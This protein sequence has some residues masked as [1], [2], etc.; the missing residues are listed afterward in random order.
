M[1]TAEKSE[2]IRFCSSGRKNITASEPMVVRSAARMA[3]KTF[4]SL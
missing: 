4:L 3:R 1:I 2:R